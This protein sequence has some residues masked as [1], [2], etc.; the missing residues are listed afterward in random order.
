LAVKKVK[1]RAKRSA[2]NKG[3]E[4]GQR[5]AFTPQEVKR[6]KGTLAR[7]GDKGLRDLALF[8]AAIDTMLHAADLLS[9]T[10]KDVRKRDGAIRDTINV[11]VTGTSSS[12]E[13]TLSEATRKLLETWLAQTSKK[14]NAPLF[15]GRNNTGSPVSPRQLS[16]L[17]K[18]WAAV[19]G[20]DA[21]AY[22]TESLR[23]TRAA[24]IM[25]RTGNLEAVRALLGHA[26]IESTARYLGEFKQADPVGLRYC[27]S[28]QSA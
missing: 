14:Q 8:S 6:I 19:I 26:K 12:V 3:V 20:L 4:V 9:L 2:W 13:C 17:V 10:V 23:R 15:T 5:A 22:G 21:T 18:G 27:A 11:A 7:R 16:R 24:H 28:G 1:K 25:R